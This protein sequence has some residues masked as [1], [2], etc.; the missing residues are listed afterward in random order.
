MDQNP[1]QSQTDTTSATPPGSAPVTP[2]ATAPYP[3]PDMGVASQ[4]DKSQAM[5]MWILTIFFGFIPSLIFFFTAKDKP[6]TYRQSAMALTWSITAAVLCFVLF[7]V[8]I[9]LALA[10]AG[11]GLVFMLLIYLIPLV[12]LILCIM[13]A[14]AASKGEDYN[15]PVV[16]GFAKSMFKV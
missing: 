6:Y 11:L 3:R 7:I 1:Q 2:P 15:P 8:S 10:T 14:M 13:G 5:L 12:N 4:D 9:I 16:S